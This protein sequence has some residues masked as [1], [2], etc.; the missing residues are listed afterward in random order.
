[1]ALA[2]EGLPEILNGEGLKATNTRKKLNLPEGS[3]GEILEKVLCTMKK[4]KR[5]EIKAGMC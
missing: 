2:V 1:M 3:P 5:T 4:P